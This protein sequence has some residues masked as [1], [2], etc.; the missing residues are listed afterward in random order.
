MII[1]II[2][3]W[4]HQPKLKPTNFQL[5]FVNLK[6]HN[7][8]GHASFPQRAQEVKVISSS[9]F[10]Q[11][12]FRSIICKYCECGHLVCD[13]ITQTRAVRCDAGRAGMVHIELE[14]RFCTQRET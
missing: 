9:S 1:I 8:G 7:F 6:H 12:T 11:C 4:T 14:W 10:G 5:L 13:A 3:K 2:N